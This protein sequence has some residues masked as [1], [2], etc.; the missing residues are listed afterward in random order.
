MQRI[1]SLLAAALLIFA[2]AGMPIAAA[3]DPDSTIPTRMSEKIVNELA[4][5]DL[6]SLSVDAAKYMGEQ[7]GE[8]IKN[9]FAS[10]K[11]LGNSNY[12]DLVYSRDYGKTSKDIIYKIDFTKAIIY[13]RLLWEIHSGDWRLEHLTF[14]SETDFPFPAGWEHIYPK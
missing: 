3:A 2:A 5:A 14:K 12:S 11:T 9:N 10:I 1:I 8:N 13:V 6:D 7:T 4:K